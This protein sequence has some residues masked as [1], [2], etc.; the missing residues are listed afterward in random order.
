VSYVISLGTYSATECVYIV[1]MGSYLLPNAG[2]MSYQSGFIHEGI[3]D[4]SRV[5]PVAVYT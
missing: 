1:T 4:H 3:R 5:I 2:C